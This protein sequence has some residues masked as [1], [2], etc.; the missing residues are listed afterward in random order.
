MPP[1]L[2]QPFLAK[3]PRDLKLDYLVKVISSEGRVVVGRVRF[4]GPVAARGDTYVGVQL[5]HGE[6]NSDGIFE[7]KRYFDW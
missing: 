1:K 7:G 5:P 6:G 4:I 3:V 2:A